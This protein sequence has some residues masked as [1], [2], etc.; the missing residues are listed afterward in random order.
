[1]FGLAPGGAVPLMDLLLS[2]LNHGAAVVLLIAIFGVSMA[3]FALRHEARTRLPNPLNA[4][5][6]QD[7]QELGFEI[8]LGSGETWRSAGR[9]EPTTWRRMRENAS[10]E[11]ATPELADTLTRYM[12]TIKAGDAADK[13]AHCLVDWSALDGAYQLKLLN[14]SVWQWNKKWMK[15]SP[16][17]RIQSPEHIV[18]ESTSSIH[19]ALHE[20]LEHIHEYEAGNASRPPLDL[21]DEPNSSVTS[22][23]T[24]SSVQTV[25]L[26]CSP[27]ALYSNPCG[28]CQVAH[29]SIPGGICRSCRSAQQ[30]ED[31]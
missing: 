22:T 28:T 12:Q 26:G 20:H 7:L 15:D 18:F 2:I 3:H 25:H 6:W 16:W 13:H 29:V 5:W 10:Q 9:F 11:V 21:I 14:G 4:V 8:H 30:P 24:L 19:A 1:V 23:G 31:A 27:G 17:K